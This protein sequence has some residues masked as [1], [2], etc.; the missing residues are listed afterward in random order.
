MM[1]E[2]LTKE[3]VYLCFIP[4][5]CIVVV[6]ILA[7]IIMRKKDK[8]FRFNYFMKVSIIIAI[9]FVLPLIAGYTAWVIKSFSERNIISSNLWYII[10]LIVLTVI[11]FVLLIIVYR[12]TLKDIKDDKLENKLDEEDL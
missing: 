6:D 12:L 7:F 4:F 10:L 9:G 2:N 5:I 8:K 11:L 1:F 3:I